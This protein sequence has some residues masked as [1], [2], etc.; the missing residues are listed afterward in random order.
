MV[1][2]VTY[3]WSTGSRL[4]YNARRNGTPTIR[5]LERIDH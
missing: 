4:I 2:V 3:H 5:T 1:N